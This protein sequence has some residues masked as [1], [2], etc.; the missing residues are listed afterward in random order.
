MEKNPPRKRTSH[1]V[2]KEIFRTQNRVL[3]SYRQ[4][5]IYIYLITEIK[6]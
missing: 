1:H 5:Y 6:T 2:E 4:I 3:I